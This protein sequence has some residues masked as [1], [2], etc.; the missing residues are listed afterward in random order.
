MLN[1][2]E[3]QGMAERKYPSYLQSLVT[4][5]SILPIRI[6]F[7][8][9]STT[10]DF[11]KL[12]QEVTALSVG[13]FGYTIEWEEKKTRKHGTQKLPSQVRFDTEDQLTKA[14]GKQRE[15]QQFRANLTD[16]LNR[17]PQLR[18]WMAAHVKWMLEFGHI[19]NELLLV[20]EYFLTNPRPGLYARQLPIAVHTKFIQENSKVLATMLDVLLPDGA[21]V[22][23]NSFEER[24]GL[25][26]LETLIR[27]RTLDQMLLS[28]LG[29]SHSE[30]GLPLGVFCNLSVRS[31]RVIITENLMNFECL[32]E[33]PNTLAIWGQGNAAELLHEVWWLTCCEVYYWGDIDEHGFH[34]LARLR[35]KFP[36]IRSLM[37]DIATLENFR[38]LTGVG[39]KAG[40]APIN[41]TDDERKAY[42]IVEQETLRLEQE[43]I[44]NPFVLTGTKWHL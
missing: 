18:E 19:W 36:G 15:V 20:C 29:L 16:T 2:K 31:I 40:K 30:M 38:I 4:G 44:P 42:D 8:V 22:E 35:R 11:A 5:E 26:P 17:L 10:E 14:L 34:I 24:F 43:K 32:P 25:K 28:R 12:Q 27:F 41:L 1:P 23:G 9:P 7:G 37:M 6:R 21:K 13:N 33:S 3:I 39:E